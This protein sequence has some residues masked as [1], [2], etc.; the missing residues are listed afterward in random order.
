M[1]TKRQLIKDDLLQ[2][3]SDNGIFRQHFIDLIDDYMALWDTKNKLIKDIKK[4]G[5]M[6][7][8]RNSDTQFGYKKNDAVSELP[9][10]N[11]Q[12][13]SLLKELGLQAVVI[14]G[15]GTDDDTDV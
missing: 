7:E 13:L 10:I 5:A 1:A 3:L 2:Q 8:W 12:M 11:K 9:K 4:R 14:K 6:I 15:D